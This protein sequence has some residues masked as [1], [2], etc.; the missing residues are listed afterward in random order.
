MVFGSESRALAASSISPLNAQHHVD[1][2]LASIR[3]MAEMT[4]AGGV[5]KS[6]Y[7]Q[8]LHVPSIYKDSY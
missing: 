8:A 1:D 2:C 4:S 7:S 5:G 6:A 3:L